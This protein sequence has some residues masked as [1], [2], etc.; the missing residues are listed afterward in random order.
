MTC[1]YMSKFFLT[2]NTFSTYLCNI[3]VVNM[4]NCLPDCLL[5]ELL[6][7]TKMKKLRH[8][9]I[10]LILEE[11]LYFQLPLLESRAPTR[12]KIDHVEHKIRLLKRRIR[13]ICK[14]LEKGCHICY[15]E[16]GILF[17]W[18]TLLITDQGLIFVNICAK[19]IWNRTSYRLFPCRDLNKSI[20]TYTQ[21]ITKNQ[22]LYPHQS[23]IRAESKENILH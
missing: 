16:E 5:R 2:P 7:V 8:Q 11:I 15:G 4:P 1:F 6:Q 10:L 19:I 23:R 12:R 13:R 21:N 3:K 20:Y 9:E 17:K 14:T 18:K 22:N